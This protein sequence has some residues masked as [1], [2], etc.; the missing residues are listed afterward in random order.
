MS[1][2]HTNADSVPGV[3]SVEDQTNPQTSDHS[4]LKTLLY[5]LTTDICCVAAGAAK[6]SHSELNSWTDQLFFLHSETVLYSKVT[7]QRSVVKARHAGE[8]PTAVCVCVC[9]L[10]VCPHWLT[11]HIFTTPPPPSDVCL[12]GFSCSGSR[13]PVNTPPH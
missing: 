9:A 11:P 2:F 8:S 6:R 12:A 10:G 7:Q 1:V 13:R 4:C 3:S 5:F